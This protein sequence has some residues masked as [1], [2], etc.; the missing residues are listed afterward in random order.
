MTMYNVNGIGSFPFY[1]DLFLLL[2]PPRD[3]LVLTMSKTVG[4]LPETGTA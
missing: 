4:V 2:S 3:L 1:I